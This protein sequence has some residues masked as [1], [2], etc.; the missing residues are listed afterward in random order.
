[1]FDTTVI[2]TIFLISIGICLFVCLFYTLY[3]L[4]NEEEQDNCYVNRN[5]QFDDEITVIVFDENDII[6]DKKEKISKKIEK[7]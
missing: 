1:M 7:I 5:V 3:N 6:S 4:F 2:T